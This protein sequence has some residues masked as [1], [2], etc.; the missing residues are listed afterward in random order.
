LGDIVFTDLRVRSGLVKQ[1]IQLSVY[2][3]KVFGSIWIYRFNQF[4][5]I[6]LLLIQGFLALEKYF[7]WRL[8]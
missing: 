2:H 3:F 5:D 1:G 7:D 4:L 6:L 8:W